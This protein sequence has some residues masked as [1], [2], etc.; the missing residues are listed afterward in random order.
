MEDDFKKKVCNLCKS[1][2]RNRQNTGSLVEALSRQRSISPQSYYGPHTSK[3]RT[4]LSRPSLVT[5]TTLSR[6]SSP[7]GTR[8][9]LSRSPLSG[10]RTTLSRTT[11]R[12]NATTKVYD[13]SRTSSSRISSCEEKRK[14]TCPNA[15]TPDGEWSKKCFCMSKKPRKKRTVKRSASPKSAKSAKS[16]KSPKSA[17]SASNDSII[18]SETEDEEEAYQARKELKKWT[19]EAKKG[20]MQTFEKKKEPIILKQS[21]VKVKGPSLFGFNTLDQI[22]NRR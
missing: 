19:D 10:T 5:R 2:S 22:L 15:N 7:S 12:S 9:T 18:D 21:P 20:K 8:T 17:K 6:A 1:L 14:K 16:A 13:S 4:T 3:T 11:S